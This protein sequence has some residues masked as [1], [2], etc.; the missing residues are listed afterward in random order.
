[1]LLASEYSLKSPLRNATIAS[2]LRAL[3]GSLFQKVRFLYGLPMYR[4]SFFF[5]GE[6]N[7]MNI[8][9]KKKLILTTTHQSQKQFG[10]N[11]LAIKINT[12]YIRQVSQVS[13]C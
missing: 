1:M 13:K 4:A 12:L 9:E 2:V 6:Q 11:V 5:C 3:A 10:P 7:K 8:G